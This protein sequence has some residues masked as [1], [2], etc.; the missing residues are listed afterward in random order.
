VFSW[1]AAG[2]DTLAPGS[3]TVEITLR[4]DGDGTLLE[5]AHR[6]LPAEELDKHGDGWSHF[7]LRLAIAGTG[8]DPGPDPWAMA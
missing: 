1:G 3:T 2:S 5:L 7:L 4:P 6:D 8:H